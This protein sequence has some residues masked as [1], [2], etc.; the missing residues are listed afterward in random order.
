MRY[1]ILDFNQEILLKF[2]SKHPDSALDITDLFILD[3]ISQAQARPEF[4]H[5][6]FKNDPLKTS[7]AHI[8]RTVLLEDLPIL[9]IK[10]SMLTKRFSKLLNLKLIELEKV[11]NDSNRGSKSF[12]R[13]TERAS[14]LKSDK[15]LLQE[16]EDDE[17]YMTRRKK[18]LLVT[19]PDVKNYVSVY[20]PI[21][22]IID[23]NINKQDTNSNN[24]NNKKIKVKIN[25]QCRKTQLISN[26]QIL[27]TQAIQL[28]EIY[29]D[30][31]TKLPKVRVL[32][33]NKMD[34]IAC[35][36]KD[37][38]HN[39]LTFDD[40]VD[41]FTEACTIAN[42]TPFL[43]GETGGTWKA[44]FNFFIS[45][46]KNEKKKDTNNIDLILEGSYGNDKKKSVIDSP[47]NKGVRTVSA[48]KEQK[49]AT[50]RMWKEMEERGEQIEY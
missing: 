9:R 40:L 28:A 21:N 16:L 17:E 35:L 4:E 48:T 6:S 32:N 46:S 37:Y 44:G 30:I 43:T 20:E 42:N 33:D 23:D 10:E 24:S 11:A 38:K 47:C 19:R 25:N 39:N 13:I 49:E 3:Y 31:C 36:V 18:L 26:N 8:E 12:Y 14:A 34:L 50:E 2:N 1:S 5:I 15:F 45:K 29:N 27:K 41:D 7:F 22:T